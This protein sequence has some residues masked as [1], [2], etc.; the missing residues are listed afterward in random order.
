MMIR[1]SLLLSLAVPLAACGSSSSKHADAA[2]QVDAAPQIDAAPMI[3]ATPPQPDAAPTP[4]TAQ[5]LLADVEGTF[6][7]PAAGGGEQALPFTHL[8]VPHQSL[9]MFATAPQYIDPDFSSAAGSVHGCLA[10]RYDIPGGTFPPPDVNAGVVSYTG[11]ATAVFPADSRSTGAYAP[12]IPGT[13]FCGWG[14]ATT[15]YY[16]CIFGVGPLM[17]GSIGGE[18]P[19]QVIFPALPSA[20]FGGTCPAGF[21]PRGMNCEQQ[22]I[23]PGTMVTEAVYGGGSYGALSK[24]VPVAGGFGAPVTIINVNGAAP[25]NPFDPFGGLTL[26]GSS[27][28]TITWSCDGS[29]TVGSGCPTGAAGF[30]DLAGLLTV[31]STNPRSMFSITP[32]FG[33][34]QCVEQLGAGT[35]TLRKAAITQILGGQSGGSVM[36]SLVRL[37]ADPASTMGHTVYFTGGIG[38]FGLLSH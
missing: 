26:D 24:L 36:I 37:S 28:V 32:A 30:L 19:S 11:Y 34:A 9:G 13:I 5:L 31:V 4:A 33:S 2:P 10:N 12:P 16:S 23:A 20:V 8:L 22:L 14:G 17:P 1:A 21:T 29:A 7:I 18:A 25:A 15:P 35:V 3:D 38:N 6:Y 27:D